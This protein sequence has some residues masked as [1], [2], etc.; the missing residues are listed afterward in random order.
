MPEVVNSWTLGVLA[1]LSWPLCV[2]LFA[3]GLVLFL[4]GGYGHRFWLVLGTTLVAG[5]IGLQYG[6][7]FGMQRLVAGLLLGVSAGAL[8]LALVRIGI[9]L[10]VGALAWYLA[11]KLAPGLNEQ[12]ACFLAG[13]L[14]GVLLFRFWIMVLTSL[15]GTV[16]MTY[17]GLILLGQ[18]AGVD[19]V[20]LT[21]NNGPL[22]NWGILGTAVL[23]LVFQSL[24]IR[25]GSG[26]GEKREK[27]HK[28]K[29][30]ERDK[31]HDEDDHGEDEK[32]GGWLSPF[33]GKRKAS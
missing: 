10:G 1:N 28:K 26:D 31:H 20:S 32:G 27:K 19:V 8:A 4:L 3:L 2:S 17:S 29:S 24:L 5:V 9:F 6:E 18:F 23:G 25:G 30:K 15:F 14:V 13:G 12:L 21:K 7:S 22:F 16:L 33:F 11:V